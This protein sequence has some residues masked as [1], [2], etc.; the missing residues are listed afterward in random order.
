MPHIHP[1][2]RSV[3]TAQTLILPQKGQKVRVLEVAHEGA[4][5]NPDTISDQFR[6]MA[7]ARI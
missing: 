2:C 4:K 1:S 5:H 3:T 6:T 7:T